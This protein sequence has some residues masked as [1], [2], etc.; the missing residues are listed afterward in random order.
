VLV[1]VD[2][3]SSIK[4][5]FRLYNGEE[6]LHLYTG[7]G[8]FYTSNNYS[9]DAIVRLDTSIDNNATWFTDSNGLELQRRVRNS[10]PWSGY[11]TDPNYPVACN[12]YPMTA[13]AFLSDVV[14]S[15][16]LSVITA[17]S[18]GVSSMRDGEL[19]FMVNR[20]V[21]D[22]FG[23]RQTGDRHVTVHDLL[24]VHPTFTDAMNSFRPQSLLLSNPVLVFGSTNADASPT[25]PGASL[26]S[27]PLPANVQLLTLQLLPPATNI[28][29]TTPQPI[30]DGVVLLRL[31]HIYA[32]QEGPL[33]TPVTLDLQALFA[34]AWTVLSAEEMTLDGTR[35]MAAARAEQVMWVQAGGQQATPA[36]V[37][38]GSANMSV[39][40]LPMQIRTF[41]LQVQSS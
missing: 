25:Q 11:Y 26:L 7:S 1:Q 31:R 9:R 29:I 40:L 23:N 32:V 13:G 24:L 21:L 2:A 3:V 36:S 17:N 14:T 15:S 27:T 12:Y 35:V 41:L 19:E 37:P 4:L 16:T 8:P 28:S 38:L 5:R 10:R 18:H 20:V 33:S 34:P 39:T 6:T 30:A 22:A